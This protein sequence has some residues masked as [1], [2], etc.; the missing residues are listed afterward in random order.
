MLYSCSVDNERGKRENETEKRRT[1]CV[2]KE[3]D[4]PKVVKLLTKREKKRVH[5]L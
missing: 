2:F 4:I 3:D 5:T 1:T